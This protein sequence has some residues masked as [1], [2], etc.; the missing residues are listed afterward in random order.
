MPVSFRILSTAS[1]TIAIWPCASPP[2]RPNKELSGSFKLR[3][4]QLSKSC[5]ELAQ[6]IEVITQVSV[7]EDRI[8]AKF[9]RAYLGIRELTASYNSV[10]GDFEAT[11]EQ[12]GQAKG[13]V[14]V[15]LSLQLS[16]N[17][18]DI[19]AGPVVEYEYYLVKASA[20]GAHD[21][22]I[23]GRGGGGRFRAR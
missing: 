15:D 6:P 5:G 7:F 20:D 11:V 23:E 17:L 22:V 13:G 19:D 16:G 9:S 4:E 12:Q 21:C 8:L 14:A 3:F 2:D 10:S 1:W 18:T